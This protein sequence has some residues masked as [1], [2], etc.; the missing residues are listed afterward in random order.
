MRGRRRGPARVNRLSLTLSSQPAG[1]GGWPPPDS[2][3]LAPNRHGPGRAGIARVLVPVKH[4][5]SAA[6]HEPSIGQGVVGATLFD[7]IDLEGM[8][9][10]ECMD[11]DG[12]H[13][14]LADV[15][16][17]FERQRTIARVHQLH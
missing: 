7:A 10:H 14:A 1:P 13:Q 2:L 5:V 6:R 11:E 3:W 16:A 15:E 8:L 9:V 4:V 12:L 17:F